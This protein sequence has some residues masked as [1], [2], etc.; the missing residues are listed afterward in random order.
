MNNLK[1]LKNIL[2]G[3]SKT[4]FN[5]V[6]ALLKLLVLIHGY[7]LM[8]SVGLFVSKQY[9]EREKE[10][11]DSSLVCANFKKTVLGL[12]LNIMR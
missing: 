1:K 8:R 2:K 10:D 12:K 11:T 5:S 6:A 9:V 3:R 4:I 7:A